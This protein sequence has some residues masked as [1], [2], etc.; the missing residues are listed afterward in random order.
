MTAI[1]IFQS[2]H[3]HSCPL[4][5]IKKAFS[6]K[7]STSGSVEIWPMQMSHEDNIFL[8]L[9]NSCVV[10]DDGTHCH[11]G[12]R[13]WVNVSQRFYKGKIWMKSMVRCHGQTVRGA[14]HP[15]W[16]KNFSSFCPLKQIFSLVPLVLELKSGMSCESSPCNCFHP[17][18]LISS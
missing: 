2:P 5:S 9:F 13:V 17:L 1:W 7:E 8:F 10:K 6:D 11:L 18:L 3:T 14:C 12:I 4:T 15:L 16:G